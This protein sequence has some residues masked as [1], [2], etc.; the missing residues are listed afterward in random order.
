MVYVLNHSVKSFSNFIILIIQS[1]S[2]HKKKLILF[3]KFFSLLSTDLSLLSKINFVTNKYNRHLTMID[4]ILYILEPILNMVKGRL[5]CYIIDNKNSLS[6]LIISIR[7]ALISFLT[8]SVPN[9]QFKEKILVTNSFHY[10]VNSNSRPWIDVESILRK[11]MQYVGLT[12]SRISY[13]YHLKYILNFNVLI[14]QL[15]CMIEIFCVK[16]HFIN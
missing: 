8:S 10:E 5:V 14:F 11:Y 15:F 7:E 2:F 12:N 3:C 9:L 13:K 1:T 6:I 4:G 16:V